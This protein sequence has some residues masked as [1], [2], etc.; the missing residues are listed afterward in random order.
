M[1]DKTV[2][3]VHWSFW[4]IGVVALIW[5]AMGVMN[6]IVQMDLDMV[7]T[8]PESHRA[9]IMSRPAWATGAFGIAVFGGV[10]GCL[11]LLLR[12]SVAFY[13]FVAS[14][15]GVIVHLF[16]FLGMIGT[17]IEALFEIVMMTL[18]PVA[19]AVFLIWYLKKVESKGW[20]HTNWIK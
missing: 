6:F 18:M 13:V 15:F 8:Y 7:A 12:K 14:L 11:L 19:S 2:K 16:S 3:V 20:I 5:N 1:N 9:I 10:L 17:T 4:I